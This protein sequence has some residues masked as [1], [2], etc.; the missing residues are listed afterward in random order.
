MAKRMIAVALTEVTCYVATEILGFVSWCLAVLHFQH[1][2]CVAP[3]NRNSSV[4]NIYREGESTFFLQACHFSTL[5][6]I[7]VFFLRY[8]YCLLSDDCLPKPQ[9]AWFCSGTPAALTACF[10]A[11]PSPACA[12]WE[13][14]SPLL[15]VYVYEK[16]C[17]HHVLWYLILTPINLAT[18]P[19]HSWFY[20][21]SWLHAEWLNVCPW[22]D[23]LLINLL[24][25]H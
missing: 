9:C 8:F 10:K 18:N 7:F 24:Y 22:M 5:L 4:K 1:V 19:S 12:S 13:C 21:W 20:F 17:S 3:R 11:W 6:N 15:S 2:N 25:G 14:C 23:R 16:S